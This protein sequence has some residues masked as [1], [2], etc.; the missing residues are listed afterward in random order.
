MRSLLPALTL[1]LGLGLIGACNSLIGA[2]APHEVPSL[3]A[4]GGGSGADAGPPCTLASDCPDQQIC[5]FQTCSKPCVADKDCLLGRCLQTQAGTACVVQSATACTTDDECPAGSQCKDAFCRTACTSDADCLTDQS[6]VNNACVHNPGPQGDAGAGGTSGGESMGGT[7]GSSG[8]GGM[9]GMGGTGGGIVSDGTA[10]GSL[11]KACDKDGAFVCVGHAQRGQLVCSNGTWQSNGTCS[12]S[13]LCDTTPGANQ[14]SC[15]AI[16][17]ECANKTAGTRFCRGTET[18][19]HAC[20][21][22]LVTDTVVDSCMFVCSAGACAGECHPGAKQCK[23]GGLI[24]QLCDDKGALQ[25]QTQCGFQ[26]D[27]ASGKC[28]AAGCKD[29]VQNGDETAKDCGGSCPGCPVD[30]ACKVNGDC[31]APASAHCANNKCVAAACND[32]V[33][34]GTETG[35]DCGG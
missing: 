10:I 17:T 15:Q 13:M 31:I 22:D 14:G 20:G 9:G 21:L 2:G 7:T 23:A 34:N 28:I 11:G 29:G 16:V 27:P 25:D 1:S 12:G 32:G 6:C 4:S 30:S 8:A 19:V 5:L 33:Q 35:K 24:P 18:D 3:A 26:C